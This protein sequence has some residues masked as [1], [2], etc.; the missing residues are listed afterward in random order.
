MIHLIHKYQPVKFRSLI[1][2]TL[3]DIGK[4]C[5]CGKEEFN[6]PIV[7]KEHFWAKQIISGKLKKTLVGTLISRSD[8]DRAAIIIEIFKRV[9]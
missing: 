2:G 6:V 8:K 4:S 5:E 1:N 7:T 9:R 3:V